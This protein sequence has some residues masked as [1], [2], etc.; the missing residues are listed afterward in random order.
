[1]MKLYGNPVSPGVV[2]GKLF[3][4]RPVKI[5]VS[6]GYCDPD[7][8]EG[9]LRRL[10]NVVAAAAEELHT[11]SATLMTEYPEKAKIFT[12]H[13][14]ILNDEALLREVASAIRTKNWTGD[15][16]LKTTFD[17]F[18]EMLRQVPDPTIKERV[19]DLKDVCVR[20]L[21]IWHGVEER[22]LSNL[23][24]PVVIAAHDL[25][26][27]DT[28]TLDRSKVQAILAEIGGATSHSAIIARSY[29]IPAILGIPNLLDTVVQDATVVVDALSGVVVFN[30]TPEEIDHYNAK[31]IQYR[32]EMQATRAF[33][34]V[35]ART[36]D[37]VRIDVGLNIGSGEENE[38]AGSDFTDYIGLFRT[39]FLYMNAPTLPDEETQFQAYKKVLSRLGSRPVTLRTLDIG[40]D[41]TLESIPLPKEDNPFLGNRALRL[42]FSHPDIF[43]T[44]LRAALRASVFGDLWLML[45]MVS[46]MDDIR[47]AKAFIQSVSDEL[48]RE[49][50]AVSD[51]FKVGIMIETPSI[52]MISDLVAP[53]VDF[54]SIGTNDLCQYLT[55]ADRLNPEVSAYYQSYH[56]GLFRMICMTVEQF[57]KAGKPISVCGELGGDALAVPVL[58][59]LGIRKLSM[60][61]ASVAGVKRML[62]TLTIEM[63]EALAN[64]VKN[65]PTAAEIECFLKSRL[66]NE[67]TKMK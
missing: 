12:A 27:S 46:S 38:L 52:A 1:M 22:N 57:N 60:G 32:S 48:K 42:C 39:E 26:P 59:G 55:A 64:T 67:F 51:T 5:V 13:E 28:A 15:R 49:G 24:H 45:P 14:D 47:R 17:G 56:P 50:T 63:A 23:P 3:V 40:G 6:E 65:L 20:L 54:A 2:I 53:E 35:E 10:D 37:N 44:Q 66:F 7:K 62:S 34:R 31:S 21:R 36:S 11:I 19:A 58:V 61:P 43:R 9:E 30:P 25:L 29:E 16:A 4:Y 33:L 41:K 18:I 8:V